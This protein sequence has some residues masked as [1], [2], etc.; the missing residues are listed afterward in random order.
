M[1]TLENLKTIEDKAMGITNGLIIVSLR[2][3]GTTTSNMAS[4]YT[5]VQ[6]LPQ[7]D[8]ESGRW[9]KGLSG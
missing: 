4:E 7:Q 1:S 3:G 8:S 2:V 9:A 5:L 6:N